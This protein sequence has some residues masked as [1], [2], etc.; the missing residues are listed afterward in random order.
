[1]S[2]C[3]F[4]TR[5]Q[6]SILDDNIEN[7]FCSKPRNCKYFAR[8]ALDTSILSHGITLLHNPNTKDYSKMPSATSR[9][10]N[11][12]RERIDN[13]FFKSPVGR[14][15]EDVNSQNSSITCSR[16]SMQEAISTT[17]TL[18]IPIRSFQKKKIP[19]EANAEEAKI[20]LN[21]KENAELLH[22]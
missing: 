15:S 20:N 8:K 22:S 13:A 4:E 5:S 12:I 19:V 3:S 16:V 6:Y 14:N 9:K 18:R 10:V 7:S 2:E 21:N 11:L 17:D 1:M